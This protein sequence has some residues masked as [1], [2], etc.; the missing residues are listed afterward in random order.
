MSQGYLI[1]IIYTL[2]WNIQVCVYYSRD[3]AYFLVEGRGGGAG[4][5]GLAEVAI[6]FCKKSTCS[7]LLLFTCM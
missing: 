1:Q 4:V 2:Y 3:F 7:S 6:L 5:G